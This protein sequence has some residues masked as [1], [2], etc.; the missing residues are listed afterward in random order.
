MFFVVTAIFVVVFVVS[1]IDVF[2]FIFVIFIIVAFWSG[3]IVYSGS[4]WLV[5]MFGTD[6]NQRYSKKSLQT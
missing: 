2:V 1:V 6:G 5:K 3:L 4:A